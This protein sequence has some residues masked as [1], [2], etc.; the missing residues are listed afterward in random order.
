MTPL[1]L[2][3]FLFFFI[4]VNSNRAPEKAPDLPNGWCDL[5]YGK[6]TT[7]TGECIC[8][9]GECEGSGCQNEQG[10]VWYEYKKCSN[11]KCMPRLK[12][13]EMTTEL[14]EIRKEEKANRIKENER[15]RIE[16]KENA[17]ND[18]NNFNIEEE[19]IVTF[20]DIL[21][22]NGRLIFVIAICIIIFIILVYPIMYMY[23]QENNIK[24]DDK[25]NHIINYK[26][27]KENKDIGDN[28]K[29]D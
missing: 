11:C 19:E 3:L 24:N 15:I 22:E 1:L 9:T 4:S 12:K 14:K 17:L 2:I 7:T 18:M 16:N 21:E 6:P 20:M 5:R 23:S 29:I 8:L 10:F 28:K 27:F 13:E 25:V 26:D